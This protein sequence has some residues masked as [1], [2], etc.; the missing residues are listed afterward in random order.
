MTHLISSIGEYKKDDFALGSLISNIFVLSNLLIDGE[1]RKCNQHVKIVTFDWLEDSL[2]KGRR[3]SERP[4]LLER[5]CKMKE[6]RLE[7][8][9]QKLLLS[10]KYT[11]PIMRRFEITYRLASLSMSR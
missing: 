1:V 8:R 3:K 6:R 9:K 5:I 2:V 11:L 4:Y 10:C 7:A